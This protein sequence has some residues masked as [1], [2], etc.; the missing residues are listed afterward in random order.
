MNF[1]LFMLA[2]GVTI[3]GSVLRPSES[4]RLINLAA[5]SAAC[6]DMPAAA[7]AY[8]R[9]C[10]IDPGDLWNRLIHGQLLLLT[11]EHA[12]ASDAFHGA[13]D[14]MLGQTSVD[15]STDRNARLAGLDALVEADEL[16]ANSME[17][18]IAS[19]ETHLRDGR[20]ALAIELLQEALG[21]IETLLAA[22][23]GLIVSK[24]RQ[25]RRP[26]AKFAESLVP[27]ARLGDVL[28][29]MMARAHLA[30]NLADS[31]RDRAL[32]VDLALW[33]T[34]AESVT[35]L[36]EM[37]YDQ[38]AAAAK[39]HPAHIEVHYRLGLIARTL[40]RPEE[41]EQAFMKV[42]R[43]HPHHVGAAA[44]LAATA[45]DLEH[46]QQVLPV[47]AVALQVTQDVMARYRG[48]ASAAATS[49]F[50]ATVEALVRDLGP[51]ADRMAVRA[52]LALAL[53][54]MGMLDEQHAEWK[55]PLTQIVA[56]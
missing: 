54:E 26:T 19:I 39:A 24:A 10:R 32:Q 1:A 5:V 37:Q 34:S 15:H 46:H 36:L 52:N 25:F 14:A 47:L 9:L 2:R 55:N 49:R 53:S 30:G 33:A 23:T 22:Q 44:R 31:L 51:A 50:D 27:L 16:P 56:A 20:F 41:A 38:L 48:L 35:R 12:A 43:L 40:N 3:N 6:G 4:R 28:L 11:S 21:N 8:A 7:D 18:L 29:R 45:L 42:L 17:Q 13:I